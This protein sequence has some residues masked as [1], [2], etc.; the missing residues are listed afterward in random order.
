[1]LRLAL[2]IPNNEIWEAHQK[3]KKNLLECVKSMTGISLSDE[4][5]T[6]G[7]A[8]R[9][10]LYKRPLLIFSDLERL[11]NITKNVGAI[12]FIFSG[13]AHPKDYEGKELIKQI[14]T[15]S[16][17]IKEIKIIYLEDYDINLA[18]LIVSGVDLWLNTPRRPMEASGTSGMKAAHNG[19]P[20]FSVLDGWWLE[21]QIEGVT[22]WS[23][24]Q[25]GDL[26]ESNE[27]TDKI[28]AD[29]MY[30]KLENVIIPLFYK[31]R[32]KWIDI[33][34]F[35]ISI[36][37]SYFNAFRMAQQYIINAYFL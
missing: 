30:K 3:A 31:E 12:Q 36:N 26:N 2:S 8:R 22:G 35:S 34:K 37:A 13:K 19:I 11:I 10:T 16:K 24:G 21:G 6:I 4:I 15:L 29:D 33:M 7:F 32:E 27:N 17:K 23:I 20:S 28:D 14:I 5:L 9:S 1:M 25:K 18:K